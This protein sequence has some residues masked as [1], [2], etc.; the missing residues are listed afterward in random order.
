MTDVTTHFTTIPTEAYG[1]SLFR[2]GRNGEGVRYSAVTFPANPWRGVER[3]IR[4]AKAVGWIS[5]AT[6][7]STA[8][9]GVLDV[10]TEDGDIVADYT[11]PDAHAFR[12]LK[13]KLH[14]VVENSE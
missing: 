2:E 12:H 1:L 10:L 14:L 4:T 8:G 3:A 7:E 11:V 5:D 13:E 6:G 9:Y